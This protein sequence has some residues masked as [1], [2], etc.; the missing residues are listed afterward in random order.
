MS[1]E[2]TCNSELPYDYYSSGSRQSL[3]SKGFRT[4]YQTGTTILFFQFL[5]WPSGES[6]SSSSSSNQWHSNPT[7]LDNQTQAGRGSPHKNLKS[8]CDFATDFGRLVHQVS[9]PVLR[10]PFHFAASLWLLASL[11]SLLALTSMSVSSRVL[12]VSA[13]QEDSSLLSSNQKRSSAS[14]SDP[15]STTSLTS[16][17]EVFLSKTH[18]LCDLVMR[19]RMS[20]WEYQAWSSSWDRKIV[21][22]ILNRDVLLLRLLSYDVRLYTTVVSLC[23][24]STHSSLIRRSRTRCALI[25]LRMCRTQHKIF[26]DTL[27]TDTCQLIYDLIHESASSLF[28]AANPPFNPEWRLASLQKSVPPLTCSGY[29]WVSFV[30]SD[31]SS[32]F[33]REGFVHTQRIKGAWSSRHATWRQRWSHPRR[34]NELQQSS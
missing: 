30:L 13:T 4:P 9:P 24:F 14:P 7:H 21:L 33:W 23:H 26:F 12:F 25:Q 29:N 16:R 10:L 15:C 32:P 28:L 3:P 34:Y 27:T 1:G 8:Y 2:L 11:L 18:S 5:H 17:V 6:E 22:K 19:Y 20:S 31:R